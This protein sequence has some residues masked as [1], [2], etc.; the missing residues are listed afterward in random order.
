MRKQ[1]TAKHH[2]QPVKVKVAVQKQ[3]TFGQ[4]II[5]FLVRM[6]AHMDTV[7]HIVRAVN[8]CSYTWRTL[9]SI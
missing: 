2:A 8:L 6:L 3:Y 4:Y 9:L 1:N 5:C 7:F